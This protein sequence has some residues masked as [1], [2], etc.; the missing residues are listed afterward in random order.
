MVFLHGTAIIHATSVGTTREEM[1]QQSLR[2]DPA[3]LDYINYVPAGRVNEKLAKWQQQGAKISYLS[4]HE[5]E[6]NVKKDKLILKKY[7]FPKGIV[8]FRQGEESYKDI[9][10]N[11]L[12]DIYIEDDCESIGGAQE[13]TSTHF[14]QDTGQK[15]KTIVIKE[16]SGIDN[17]PDN[18][19]ELKNY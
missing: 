17:L 10:E 8:Y 11:V 2:R 6:D 19:E 1:V 15:I 4:S 5:N 7:G 9:V 14:N 12:P 13:M 3:V 16:F 18:L